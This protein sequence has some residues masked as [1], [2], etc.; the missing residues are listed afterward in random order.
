MEGVSFTDAHTSTPIPAPIPLAL[1]R[2]LS[3]PTPTR[4]PP[5]TG[6]A[7]NKKTATPAN[8]KTAPQTNR[9]PRTPL[10]NTNGHR[11]SHTPASTK[12]N[13]HVKHAVP[14]QSSTQQPRLVKALPARSKMAFVAKGSLP[15]RFVDEEDRTLEETNWDN[16]PEDLLNLKLLLNGALDL[17]YSQ[18]IHL[19]HLRNPGFFMPVVDEIDYRGLIERLASATSYQIVRVLVYNKTDG[20]PVTPV[21]TPRIP[22]YSLSTPLLSTHKAGLATPQNARSSGTYTPAITT[23]AT[24]TLS[25]EKAKA[26]PKLAETAAPSPAKEV[27]FQP[28]A[29]S[30]L[31]TSITA[32]DVMTQSE[33][34]EVDEEAPETPTETLQETVQPSGEVTKKRKRSQED[35][36]D[37]HDTVSAAVPAEKTQTKKRKVNEAGD[38]ASS[39]AHVEPSADAGVGNKSLNRVERRRHRQEE[40]LKKLKAAGASER[41]LQ[42]ARQI[43]RE[44]SAQSTS[45]VDP[46]EDG[47]VS[48]KALKRRQKRMRRKERVQGAIGT[49]TPDVTM[50][51][52]MN[53]SANETTTTDAPEDDSANDL[54]KS[55]EAVLPNTA[56]QASPSDLPSAVSMTAA[57]TTSTPDSQQARKTEQ[58][59]SAQTPSPGVES[60]D[61]NQ[62]GAT[63][64]KEMNKR[65]GSEGH[66]QAASERRKQASVELKKQKRE[67][68]KGKKDIRNSPA[69]G[70]QDV[71]MDVTLDDEAVDDSAND[72]VTLPEALPPNAARENTSHLLSAAP[73]QPT[74]SPST[75]GKA[76]RKRKEA[77]VSSRIGQY[78]DEF[79]KDDL[80]VIA[81]TSSPPTTHPSEVQPER[82]QNAFNEPSAMSATTLAV[83]ELPR[84]APTEAIENESTRKDRRRASGESTTPATKIHSANSESTPSQKG[85]GAA[86]P[87]SAAA[88]LAEWRAKHAVVDKAQ[89]TSANEPHAAPTQ[90]SSAPEQLPVSSL[91][92]SAAATIQPSTEGS[93][94][95]RPLTE[96]KV[97]RAI[98][99]IQQD[100]TESQEAETPP[101]SSAQIPLPRSSQR[102][103]RLPSSSPE[104]YPSD[105][106]ESQDA[107]Q[108]AHR[109]MRT[110][111]SD[112]LEPE[113]DDEDDDEDAVVASD[114]VEDMETNQTLERP[115]PDVIL[116]FPISAPASMEIDDIVEDRRSLSS[117]T[118]QH[119]DRS[120]TP[121]ASKQQVLEA[122]AESTDE[123]SLPTDSEMTAR[124]AT[125]SLFS[126]TQNPIIP[127][128]QTEKRPSYTTLTDLAAPASPIMPSTGVAAFQDAMDE[129][130]AADQAA[131]DS[132]TAVEETSASD[133][134][135]SNFK[136]RGVS[137]GNGLRIDSALSQSVDLS[138]T[139]KASPR[140]LRSR[141]REPQSQ[142]NLSK[143]LPIP[144]PTPKKRT[145]APK[146]QSQ[147]VSISEE[148][149]TTEDPGHE[150]SPAP[151]MNGNLNVEANTTP[152]TN[153]KERRI[154]ASQSRIPALSSLSADALRKGRASRFS[155]AIAPKFTN[156]SATQPNPARTSSQNAAN[157]DTDEDAND[158]SD[159]ESDSDDERQNVTASLPADL[160]KRVAGGAQ[161]R[162]SRQ[163]LGQM[164]GW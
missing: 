44:D 21:Q 146:A 30:S 109:R 54:V 107:W 91:H 130:A 84:S 62:T 151:A 93:Q 108:K 115:T 144:T 150:Q 83:S 1:P 95:T 19:E 154:A 141:T 90:A 128:T 58:K 122:E 92:D 9:Q 75:P 105:S 60:A 137:K 85:K 31:S 119:L 7:S 63:L 11:A 55:S 121:Q 41:A 153:R 82:S 103:A 96:Q 49:S 135:N 162:K 50:D 52:T 112:D 70:I 3:T 61:G 161:P 129:D 87:S 51:E 81:T 16:L 26:V 116:S 42:L 14:A 77:R 17:R 68:K 156:G 35:E 10:N 114:P 43:E 18:E 78:V 25:R 13:K 37:A 136:A 160:A 125:P 100:E 120:P 22:S 73:T 27:R 47:D 53:D 117:S 34:P 164:Q 64:T 104:S 143:P 131:I 5:K 20:I 28:V 45:A 36:V 97:I 71:T 158:D 163:S 48:P 8:K 98:E 142:T 134:S 24:P 76:H 124:M 57:T 157:S 72:N 145:K 113:G 127:L 2:Q 152:M 29:R 133:A 159:S 155:T 123:V 138:Q 86:R 40:E 6:S 33:A 147:P 111:G 88:A 56:R 66:K 39:S 74:A 99:P 46:S 69:A 4:Q 38:S 79:T 139:S 148:P 15:V 106:E 140:R 89:A 67:R 94:S 110:P 102:P 80:P 126:L 32:D 59:I 118:T 101:A 65:Q 132:V 149:A 23:L 12:A